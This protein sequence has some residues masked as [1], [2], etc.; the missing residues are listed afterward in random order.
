[1][2]DRRTLLRSA[3]ASVVLLGTGAAVAP[4][5][6]AYTPRTKGEKIEPTTWQQQVTTYWC[7]PAAARIAVSARNSTPPS[8]QTLASALGT[9]TGGTNFGNMAPVLTRYV[10]NANYTA[11]WIDSWTATTT[12]VN[13]L[14][15]RA[16]KNVDDGYATVCNWI[17]LPGQYP[18]WGGNRGTIYHYVTIDGYD[19]RYRTLRISDPAGATLSSSLPSRYWLPVARVANYCAGRGYFW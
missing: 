7:G 16:T 2:I 1:M 6:S 13:T 18:T 14:W 10:P 15:D 3:G 5:A 12:Q 19:T 4:A 17:V 8:Q 9:T 11:Q